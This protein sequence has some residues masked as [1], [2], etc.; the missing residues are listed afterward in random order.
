MYLT[1][2]R[3]VWAV[4]C[5]GYSDDEAELTANR[6]VEVE[7]MLAEFQSGDSRHG[8][9]TTCPPTQS[10]DKPWH[11]PHRHSCMPSRWHHSRHSYAIQLIHSGTSDR[12]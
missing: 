7:Q 4:C 11:R 9:T 10:T 3:R 6:T 2:W 5:A 12:G 8:A 1:G